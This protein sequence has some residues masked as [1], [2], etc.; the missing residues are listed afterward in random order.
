MPRLTDMKTGCRCLFVRL[1]SGGSH[2]AQ[3][4]ADM[5]L[6]PGEPLKILQNQGNGP[7][8]IYVKGSRIALGHTMAK[9]LEVR[10]ITDG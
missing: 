8:T 3:R 5:G 4:L 7:V 6:L 2:R 10:E 1:N 9:A